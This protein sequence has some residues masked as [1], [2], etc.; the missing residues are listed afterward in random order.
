M[1]ISDNLYKYFNERI[2]K[3]VGINMFDL[4]VVNAFS[5]GTVI[6][7]KSYFNSK[8]LKGDV[9]IY[10]NANHVGGVIVFIGINHWIP[11]SEAEVGAKNNFESHFMKD[12]IDGKIKPKETKELLTE[13][14]SLK[15][16][17]FSK[18]AKDI[19]EAGREL[20]KYYH[21]HDLININA[22]YYDIRKFFQG[23]DSKSGR[24]NNKS[25]DETYNKLIGNLRERMKIL[26]KKIEPKIYEF[27][28]LKK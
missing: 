26:A 21:K 23:V 2:I 8:V 14:R 16:I 18:E 11:F 27:G 12:F 7:L 6:I 24:M 4:D 3:K 22:S 15:P 25:I 10:R 28:F 5:K 19:F 1:L 13:R 20:W 17:K 9:R